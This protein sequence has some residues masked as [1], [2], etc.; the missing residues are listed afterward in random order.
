MGT[1]TRTHSAVA[2]R[3][4][5]R[6]SSRADVALSDVT[7]GTKFDQ[8][9]RRAIARRGTTTNRPPTTAIATTQR[10]RRAAFTATPA[11]RSGHRRT[12]GAPKPAAPST[13]CP[14]G[15]AAKSTNS[16]AVA[17]SPLPARAAIG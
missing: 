9:T 17:V 16:C 8:S 10:G 5:R 1:P 2:V 11:R 4:V 15:P 7:S 12:Q 6:L 14:D 13:D 3:E